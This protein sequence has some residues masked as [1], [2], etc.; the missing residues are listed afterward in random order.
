MA[1]LGYQVKSDAQIRQWQHGYGG[2]TPS[3]ENCT[4][5]WLASNKKVTRQALRPSDYW[6][7]WPD[8]PA[9]TTKEPAHA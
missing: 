9:P 6:L 7:I 3:A 5:I 4:G 2:R 1:A 8:L